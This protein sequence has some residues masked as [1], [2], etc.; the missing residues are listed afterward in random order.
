MTYW[1]GISDRTDV[2]A[3]AEALG[4]IDIDDDSP[5]S[6]WFGEL[7]ASLLRRRSVDADRAHIDYDMKLW[8]D[9][10]GARSNV[11]QLIGLALA[12]RNL[13]SVRRVGLL[14]D[15]APILL[16]QRLSGDVWYN[17]SIGRVQDPGFETWVLQ[18]LKSHAIDPVF[19]SENEIADGVFVPEPLEQRRTLALRRVDA[20]A[21]PPFDEAAGGQSTTVLTPT[22]TDQA[23][24]AAIGLEQQL[25]RYRH[26]DNVA[27]LADRLKPLL[28]GALE[29]T[30]P[31]EA[32][33]TTVAVLR[34]DRQEPWVEHLDDNPAL[35]E[36]LRRFGDTHLGT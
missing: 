28:R 19:A 15:D 18:A 4:A 24:W 30:Q 32:D 14:L 7:D 22:D 35:S 21:G 1:I 26:T 31:V 9:V 36:A 29:P 34:S 33:E 11:E 6:G 17:R 12:C 3:V 16:W 20:L 10:S 8:F 23:L 2:E 13:E 5:P 25:H 27:V